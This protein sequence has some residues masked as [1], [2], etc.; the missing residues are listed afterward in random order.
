MSVEKMLSEFKVWAERA[1]FPVDLRD[2]GQFLYTETRNAWWGWRGRH[3]SLEVE[4]PESVSIH[5]TEVIKAV[6][7]YI[8]KQGLKVKL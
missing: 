2:D 7:R 1:S 5:N 4:L 6:G 3:E 8:I